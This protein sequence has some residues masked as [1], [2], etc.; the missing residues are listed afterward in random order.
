M[1]ELFMARQKFS[2]F[3]RPEVTGGGPITD[4]D[5]DIVEAILR[6]RF[7]PASQL[8][9]LVGGNE[10]VTQRRLR[11]LWEKG[12]I[13]RWAFPGIRTHSEFHYYLDS[14]EP[15]NLL[16]ERR[17]LE[18]HPQMQEEIKSNREKDYAQAAFRG[19]HM[20]LGFLAH[21]LMISRMH[22]MLEMACRTSGAGA[23][24]E[25]W[26]QGGQLAG[27]KVEVPKVK[28]SRGGTG[29][30]WEEASETERL[31]VE[32]DGMFT[33]RLTDRPAG[34]QLVHF[35]YEADRGT[36]VM[37]DMLKKLRGYYHL[38]KKQQKHKEAFG[39][40]PIRAV[41]VET[42]DEARGKRLMELVNHPLVCGPAK[43]AGLFWF[44]ITPQ[45]TDPTA[46]STLP[47]H[48]DHP[49]IILDSIW[50]LPDLTMHALSDAENSPQPA[51]A[52]A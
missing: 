46:G 17:G 4:R 7:A 9:R 27:R 36:M 24:L 44:T 26:C 43:R 37:T 45:F 49:E 15:L 10:D 5:L 13:N 38:I 21:C 22:F 14:R 16:A 32:P 34:G 2:K 23:R 3:I 12:L 18:I 48:L 31:P 41:L 30:F 39:I 1:E 42:T 25:A 51:V 20:Q 28:S 50:A 47:G 6:Y 35:F 11:R 40:H 33:L 8:V 52:K 19:Q 29:Y